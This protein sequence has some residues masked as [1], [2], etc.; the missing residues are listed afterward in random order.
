M[1]KD[2]S[3]FFCSSIFLLLSLHP[4]ITSFSRNNDAFSL[5]EEEDEAVVVVVWRW[6]VLMFPMKLWDE[7]SIDF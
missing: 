4:M 1:D 2:V 5:V 7:L 6:E 3:Y